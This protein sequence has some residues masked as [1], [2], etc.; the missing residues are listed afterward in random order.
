MSKV[1]QYAP[2]SFSWA[3]LS[4]PD[5]VAAKGFYAELFG[6][7][8]DDQPAGPGRIY[9]MAK[10]AGETAAAL[11]EQSE[12][13]SKAGMPPHWNCYFTVQ[14]V[15]AAAE[16]VAAAGGSVMM[17][18][19]DVF[20]SGRMCIFADPSGGAAAL[21]QPKAHIGSSVMGVHGSLCWAELL[22]RDVDRAAAFLTELFGAETAS[23]PLPEGGA[24]T[25]LKIEGKPSCGMMAMPEA[26]PKQLPSHWLPYFLV[27]DCDAT[28]AKAIAGGGR[29]LCPIMEMPGVGRFTTLADA[30]GA[31]FGILKGTA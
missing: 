5:P 1:T 21:W 14:D 25:L 13:E 11:Y 29:A 7:I 2:G 3:D 16:Y 26:L 20:D 6:W 17:A 28:V 22:S 12:E 27:D 10:A 8:Y 24:Y 19:F 31:V 4:T 18:P 30:Q 15:E 23:M 9:S